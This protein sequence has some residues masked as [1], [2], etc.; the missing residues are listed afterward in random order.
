MKYYKIASDIWIFFI[1]AG[2]NLQ[3][4]A[5]FISAESF[6]TLVKE[7]PDVVVLDANKTKKYMMGLTMSRFHHKM[8]CNKFRIQQVIYGW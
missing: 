1:I 8:K 7:N 5:S 3:A 4:Q 2:M 6:M